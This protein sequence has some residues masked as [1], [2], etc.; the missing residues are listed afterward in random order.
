MKQ[1]TNIRKAVCTMANELKKEG[2][3]FQSKSYVIPL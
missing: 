1:I 3:T 2:Y